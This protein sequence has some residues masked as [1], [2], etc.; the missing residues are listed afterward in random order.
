MSAGIARRVVASAFLFLTA[1][2]SGFLSTDTP[3][4]TGPVDSA[5]TLTRPPALAIEAAV[6]GRSEALTGSWADQRLPN[7]RVRLGLAVLV[8]LTV[9]G[10][11]AVVT[12]TRP[13]PAPRSV[14]WRRSSVALRA[15][16]LL[17]LS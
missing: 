14:L 3:A 15:P 2:V 13:S 4:K 9:L 6:K 16:P 10:P 12:L 11:A 17:Q 7:A 1:A 5:V 8:G